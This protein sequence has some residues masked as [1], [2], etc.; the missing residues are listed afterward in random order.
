ME[1]VLQHWGI[2]NMKWG[3]RRFQNPDGSLTEEGR[4]RYNVG[5]A[6]K[7]RPEEMSND[8]LFTAAKRFKA[9]ENYY[10]SENNYLKAMA[11]NKELTTP[12]KKTNMF[13]QN[14]FLKP[15]ERF[16]SKSVEFGLSAG[17]A[18]FLDSIDSKYADDYVKFIMKGSGDGKKNED[19]DKH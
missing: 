6:R 10:N 8:E 12:K 14:I 16:L 7:K 3:V 11:Y 9:Q 1:N 13:L 18:A 15:T 2:L 19:K 5:P 17:A 4:K